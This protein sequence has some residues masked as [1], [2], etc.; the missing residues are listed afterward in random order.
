MGIQACYVLAGEA[1]EAYADMIYVSAKMLRR[2][3]PDA[4]VV[5]L[6][7][8]PTARLLEHRA[9]RLLDGVVEPLRLD[10][11][12]RI[13]AACEPSPVVRSRAMKVS[14]RQALQG[15]FIYIDADAIPIARFDE[16]LKVRA[17]FAAVLDRR[18]P[19]RRPSFP[20]AFAPIFE[21]AGWANP[22]PRYI[23]T[24]VMLWRD[25]PLM[26]RVAEDWFV[27]WKRFNELSGGKGFD[28]PAL[29]SA[30]HALEVP[31]R[32]MPLR[33][34][35]MVDVSPWY[36]RGAR[37]FHYYASRNDDQLGSGTLLGHLVT[38]LR[39]TGEID[40]D[41]IDRAAHRSDAWTQPRNAVRWEIARGRY[42]AAASVV[43]HRILRRRGPESAK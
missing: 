24:G 10:L 40:W 11:A 9:H 43:I 33:F 36:S 21:A 16:M 18:L 23:N 35:A 29:N 1:D 12:A 20:T 2:L 28:Q 39:E 14:I 5:L 7:D 26:H 4:R 41:V 6:L 15:D 22:L 38:H 31:V 32:V 17:P 27:R 25:T 30:L 3:Y 8:E 42:V 34:N 13:P 37:I 19:D